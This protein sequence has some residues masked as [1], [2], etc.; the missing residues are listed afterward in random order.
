MASKQEIW[1]VWKRAGENL[2][3]LLARFKREYPEMEDV[4]V[5]Y[6]G[7]L[8][9]MAEGLVVLLTGESVHKKD[10]FLGLDKVYKF[11]VLWGVETDTYD[12]LGLI[13]QIS[14]RRSDFSNKV[15][16]VASDF[17]GKQIQSYPPYSSKPVDGKPMFQWAREGRIGE[18]D[19]QKNEIEVFS[20]EVG[21]TR[22]LLGG[23]LLANIEEKISKV[24]GDFRQDEIMKS[25]KESLGKIGNEKFYITKMKAHVSSG[26]YIRTLAFEVGK[27]I[28][29]GAIAF[30]IVRT[31]VGE[32]EKIV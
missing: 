6:A 19:I 11:E 13:Q 26:T 20:I 29:L 1:P 23:E 30:S 17:V 7:R 2:S 25:W 4:P 10:E 16:R 18:I 5:T 14:S 31:K 32:L 22:A 21:E 24:N 28:G 8:D 27:K 9:P 3:E 15:Q 12:A